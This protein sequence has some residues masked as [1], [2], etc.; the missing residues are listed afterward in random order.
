MNDGDDC[1]LMMINVVH[2]NQPCINA[3]FMMVKIDMCESWLVMAMAMA[4][5]GD[6]RSPVTITDSCGPK[7]LIIQMVSWNEKLARV[8]HLPGVTLGVHLLIALYNSWC[9]TRWLLK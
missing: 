6:R 8:R 1:R 2:T 4:I 3:D 7:G 9:I 5:D